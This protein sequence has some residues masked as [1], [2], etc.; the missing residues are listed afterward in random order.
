[1]NIWETAR[2]R[3][4]SYSSGNTNCVEVAGAVELVGVRDS[5]DR[6][7]GPLVLAA[8]AWSALLTSMRR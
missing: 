6:A 7:A 5:K 3:T 2:W 8:P 1:M 4:S